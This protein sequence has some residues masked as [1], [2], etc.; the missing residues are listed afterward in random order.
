MTVETIKIIRELCSSVCFELFDSLDC[1]AMATDEAHEPELDGAPIANIDVASNDL[2]IT[3]NLRLPTSILALTYPVTGSITNVGE[4]E[5]ED[6][7]SEL[8]NQFMGRLKAKLYSRQCN[9]SLGLP[10]SH[11]DTNIDE[12][13][14]EGG[15]HEFLYFMV[16]QEPCGCALTVELFNED[17][18][19]GDQPFEDPHSASEGDIELF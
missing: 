13:L 9:V 10:R 8:S 1:V 15:H 5:L 19:I 4:E 14:I 17:L 18:C 7:L 12:L 2:E 6:W 3:L 16:D 11:F